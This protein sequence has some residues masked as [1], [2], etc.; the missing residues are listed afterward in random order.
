VPL[1]NET[2]SNGRAADWLAPPAEQ[3][4]LR[5]YVETLR[6]R[7]WM[8]VL[9]V[10]V[11][12]AAAIAYVLTAEKQYEAEADLLVTPVSGSDTLLGQLGLIRESTDPTRDVETASRLTTTVDVAER[13][14]EQLELSESPRDLLEDV[15]AEPVAQSNVVAV[16]ARARTPEEAQELANAFAAGVVDDRTEQLHDQIEEVLPDLRGGG[17]PTSDEET[18]DEQIARLEALSAGPDPTIRVETR[19]DVPTDPVSPKPVLSVAGGLLGGLVLGVAMAFG[20][21]VL[22]PR[23]R[24]EDQLRRHYRLPILARIPSEKRRIRGAPLGPREVTPAVAEG[25]RTLRGTLSMAGGRGRNSSR[26]TLVTGASPGEGKTTTAINLAAS[27]ALAGNH[28]IL[29]EADLRRP[30]IGPAVGVTPQRGVV[31]VLLGNSRLEDAL[32]TSPAYGP[33]FGFLLADREGGW[34]TELF[35]LPTAE[36]LVEDARQLADYVVIDS[37]PLT[38]VIDALPLAKTVDDVLVVVR[39]GRTRLDKVTRLGE[40]LA[41]SGIR[42]VGFA[43]VGTTRP[44]RGDYAYYAEGRGSNGRPVEAPLFHSPAAPPR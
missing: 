9:A 36:K 22:D 35:S 39:V 12:T 33:N 3:Q 10:I 37:P 44:G 30:A 1:A 5:R 26:A 2:N 20:S 29:I 24:R 23:L 14:R 17:G 31:S 15:S 4:G 8:V 42:P 43:V 40:V 16:S 41:E 6:E 18:A 32:V 27:L 11:T 19:A 34:I 38:E 21:Q 13:V 7:W 25:Y 28:V